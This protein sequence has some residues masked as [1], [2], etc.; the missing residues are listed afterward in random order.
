MLISELKLP[1]SRH[2][3]STFKL[4]SFARTID[5]TA[6][7]L[8]LAFNTGE[9]K[10]IKKDILKK[11]KILQLHHLF[12][13]SGIHFSA[14]M[15]SIAPFLL[16]IKKF[17]IYFFFL[18][19]IAL[20]LSP[21]LLDGFFSLKRIGL[22]KATLYI[23]KIDPFLVF[24]ITF[25]LDFLFGT[26]QYSHLS[27]IYSFLFLGIIL[28]SNKSNIHWLPFNLLGGQ[29]IIASLS[30][31]S[32][33]IT[34]FLFS[35]ILTSIFSFIFPILFFCFWLG[36]IFFLSPVLSLINIYDQL[37]LICANIS[38]FIGS[39]LPS[40]WL[41]LPII[42]LNFP[43]FKGKKRLIMILIFLHASPILSLPRTSFIQGQRMNTFMPREEHLNID[44]I[45]RTRRGY[46]VVY[47]NG[48][49]CLVKIYIH[50]YLRS[51]KFVKGKSYL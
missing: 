26:Y 10:Q 31:K 7:S 13:P 29:I 19:K 48:R 36:E 37:V 51:C 11:Y 30:F 15:I 46:K 24:L 3:K 14:V 49:R 5:S 44:F 28:S 9:K 21:F 42:I 35:F 12:V 45:K 32:L 40:L 38:S 47:D 18:V 34:G 8:L 16:F 23:I 17:N 25:F 27:F 20:S 33:T 2:K 50:S 4:P 41:L 43:T 1:Y 6:M 22:F 39:Y